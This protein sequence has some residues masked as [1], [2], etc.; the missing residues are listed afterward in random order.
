MESVSLQVA[1][2]GQTLTLGGQVP[3]QE[4]KAEILAKA[5]S[6]YGDDKV[7]D[8]MTIAPN[9]LATSEG[10]LKGAL[11]ALPWAKTVGF[12]ATDKTMTLQGSV[13][14]AK[15]KSDTLTLATNTL[16]A[17]WTID[18]RLHVGAGGQ[19][20]GSLDAEIKDGKVSLSGTV[21]STDARSGIR[22]TA[23]KA[24]GADGFVETLKVAEKITPVDPEWLAIAEKAAVWGKIAPVFLDGKTA[25]LRG[26]MPTTAAKSARYEYVRKTLGAGWKLVDAMTVKA[27]E[28]PSVQNNPNDTTA[29]NLDAF[30]GIEFGTNSAEL[31]SK[32]KSLLDGAARVISGSGTTRYEISGHTDSRGSETGNLALSEARAKSVLRY[33]L[34]KGIEEVRLEAKG[35]GATRPV[36]P[37]DTPSNQARNRRI[38][39]T[40]RK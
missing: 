21:P 33:L 4:A 26:E 7:V 31:T 30:K 19:A 18:D 3:S 17:G 5:K 38:E 20:T 9:G 6:L 14:T 35:Y 23:T 39:F 10:W 22:N 12:T 40:E 2:S 16:G 28:N 25:T 8:S 34:D 36:A 24:L 11:A 13:P 15:V 1:L 29:A 27:T 37:N 32:G